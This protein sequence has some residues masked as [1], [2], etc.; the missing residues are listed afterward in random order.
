VTLASSNLEKTKYFWSELLGLSIVNSTS[1]TAE[2]SF[3]G[4][5]ASL[6]FQEIEGEIDHAEA[7]GRIAFA[8]PTNELAPLQ[9][10]M[11]D[12]KQTILKKSVSLDTPGK[13]TVSVVILADPVSIE[14]LSALPLVCSNCQILRFNLKYV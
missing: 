7:Y 8:I 4:N 10:L 1:K 11:E 5:Q 6:E 13:A 3:S 9:A 2:F 12:K 14:C